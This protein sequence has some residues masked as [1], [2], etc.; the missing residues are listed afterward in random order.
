MNA[1]DIISQLEA[2]LTEERAAIARLDGARVEV[3]ATQ[4]M[5]LAQA[6][7]RTLPESRG[8]CAGPL[9]TLVRNLKANGVL[10]AQARGILSDF[11]LGPGVSLQKREGAALR[12]AVVSAARHLSVRG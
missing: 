12:G 5:D 6:L 11:L 7:E 10:L 3:L 1:H 8:A 9:K 2:L 4:K